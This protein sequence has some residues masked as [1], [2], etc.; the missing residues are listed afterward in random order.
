MK[1]VS[2]RFDSLDN[3]LDDLETKR[4]QLRQV[5]ASAAAAA[6]AVIEVIVAAV[7]ADP[8]RVLVGVGRPRVGVGR[9]WWTSGRGL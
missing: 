1:K 2:D 7:A 6:A 8:R 5:S 3:K 4:G 9:G